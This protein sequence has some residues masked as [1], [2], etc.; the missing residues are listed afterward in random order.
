MSNYTLKACYSPEI[1]FVNKLA[2]GSR[3]KLET[4]YTYNVKY[5]HD[6]T[7]KGE[8]IAEVRDKDAPELFRLKV[9]TVGIFS[10]KEG[11]DKDLLHID[12]YKALF[13]YLRALVSTVTANT[14]IPAIILPEA[15][16]EGQSIYR[17]EGLR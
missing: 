14:G 1:Q 6:L 10:F 15:D 11:T 3:I 13:P 4:K 8:L 2:N 5:S 16:M 12:T 17:I 9:I 7:C